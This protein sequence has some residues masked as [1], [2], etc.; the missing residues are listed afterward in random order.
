MRKLDVTKIGE[1]TVTGE[2][3]SRVIVHLQLTD[4]PDKSIPGNTG[5]LVQL[6]QLTHV[7]MTTHNTGPQ[8]GPLLVHCSAG[9]GR[10]GECNKG[11]KRRSYK[12]QINLFNE[13]RNLCL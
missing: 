5:H 8:S 9:V 2:P 7:L 3:Q 11:V 13:L 12:L 6:V 10:T 1:S 4:W